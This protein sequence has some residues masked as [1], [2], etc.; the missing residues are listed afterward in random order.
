[1][2]LEYALAA[3]VIVGFGYFIYRKVTKKKGAGTGGG[4]GGGG[5]SDGNTNLN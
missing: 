2:F 3:A 4:G 5:P 1:M